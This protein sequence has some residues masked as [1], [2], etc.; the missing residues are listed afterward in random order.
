MRRPRSTDPKYDWNKNTD[1]SL[2]ERFEDNLGLVKFVI[3]RFFP[4]Q[5]GDEDFYQEACLA[6]WKAVMKYDPTLKVRFSPFATMVIKNLMINYLLSR[7]IHY[8]PT[9]ELPDEMIDITQSFDLEDVD[10]LTTLPKERNGEIAIVAND[11]LLGKTSAQTC[12]EQGWRPRHYKTRKDELRAELKR[13][14]YKA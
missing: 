12:A 4:D 2:Y 1:K 13:R 9:E 14:Y 10:F 7:G 6:L 3:Q 8:R 11:I 5:D